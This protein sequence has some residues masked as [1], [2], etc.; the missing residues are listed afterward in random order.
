MQSR[1]K[2]LKFRQSTPKQHYNTPK[3]RFAATLEQRKNNLEEQKAR[4]QFA[5]QKL[6]QDQ[7]QLDLEMIKLQNQQEMLQELENELKTENPTDSFLQENETLSPL[8]E[9]ITIL[10]KTEMDL[11]QQLRAAQIQM[12]R[13]SKYE[14]IDRE[15]D[16][17]ERLNA[18]EMKVYEKSINVKM[19]RELLET[20]RGDVIAK[21]NDVI[22]LEVEAI[23]HKKQVDKA[24]QQRE[25]LLRR[26]Q[27]AER[28]KAACIQNIKNCD[29]LKREHEKKKK[30][31]EVE[32]SAIQIQTESLSNYEKELD[33][34]EQELKTKKHEY[35]KLKED[36]VQK[37]VQAVQNRMARHSNTKAEI[38][39]N[40]EQNRQ[41]EENI[42]LEVQMDNDERSIRNRKQDLEIQKHIQMKAWEENFKRINKMIKDT[43]TMLNE[44]NGVEDIESQFAS[45]N[46]ENEKIKADIAAKLAEIDKIKKELKTDEEMQQIEADYKR[47]LMNLMKQESEYR[48]KLAELQSNERRLDDDQKDL[49]D[50]KVSLEG[51][52]EY[53]KKIDDAL[54]KGLV[55]SH[56]NVEDAK[57]RFEIA[58]K[59]YLQNK[60]DQ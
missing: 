7:E 41:S 15:S 45:E 3:G 57:K 34:K 55:S 31:L 38:P 5:K 10:K 18:I 37:R 25:D 22:S 56:D 51:E 21:E 36:L 39:N 47:D 40:D 58:K 1:E 59:N 24:N 48:L 12:E 19:L 46:A 26:M 50:K 44:N 20:L 43:E 52:R 42:N 27:I 53:L 17:S 2:T 29:K 30:N 4:L 11:T 33:Q 28:E 13:T 49:E 23:Q 8:Q 54:D 32:L 6:K 35:E 14:L 60:H 16:N 9:Q